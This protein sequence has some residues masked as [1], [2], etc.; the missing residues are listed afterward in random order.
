M[1][2]EQEQNKIPAPTPGKV[3]DKITETYAEDVAKAIGGSQG[4]AL[5]KIIHDEE[6]REAEKRNLFP[7][8]R[9]N[10]F[11]M[12]AGF[13]LLISSYLLIFFF[14]PDREETN[15]FSV[16]S[17][18]TSIIFNDKTSFIEV[19]NLTKDQIAKMIWDEASNS[20]VKYEGIEGIYLNANKRIIGLREFITLLKSTLV[21]D[22]PELVDDNFLLG[23]YVWEAKSPF[24][25]IEIRTLPDIFPSMRAWED[26]MFYDLH[27]L[28]GLDINA[29]TNYL[30]TKSFEDGVVEN[31]NARILYGVSGEIILMYVFV[32]D[33]HLIIAN[34]LIAVHEITVR[35]AGSRIK[36]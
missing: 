20:D 12:L 4:E 19:A 17:E 21:L 5:K 22:S 30:L 10:K 32:D 15:E 35:L 25:L 3:P 18:S 14:F 11:F 28:F 23:V 36:Q 27:G 2:E 24:V 7:E 13:L 33:S 8:S 9:R 6:A 16:Q 31:K 26:K 29:D 34:D 1:D